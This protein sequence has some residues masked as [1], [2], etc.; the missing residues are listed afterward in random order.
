[1]EEEGKVLSPWKLTN[2]RKKERSLQLNYWPTLQAFPSIL[3]TLGCEAG[4]DDLLFKSLCSIFR[5]CGLSIFIRAGLGW[6]DRWR[7]LKEIN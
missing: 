7:R 1:M 6:E 2:T 3:N 5:T 4:V